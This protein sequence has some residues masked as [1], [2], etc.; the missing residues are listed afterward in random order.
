MDGRWSEE[1]LLLRHDEC[2]SS[3]YS[4]NKND[5]PGSSNDRD[6]PHEH[7]RRRE[8]QKYLRKSCYHCI[9]C[10][11]ATFLAAFIWRRPLNSAALA[12]TTHRKSEKVSD[13]TGT[14]V[15]AQMINKCRIKMI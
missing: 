9:K 5:P 14:Q 13:G 11:A 12:T 3:I 6:V 4:S 7:T 10:T 8:T 15:R 1:E 2:S